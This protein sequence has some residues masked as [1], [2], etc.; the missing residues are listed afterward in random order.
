MAYGTRTRGNSTAYNASGTIGL[1]QMTDVT[2]E[3]FH[4]RLADG[5]LINNPMTRTDYI[6]TGPVSYYRGGYLYHMYLSNGKIF[7]ANNRQHACPRY[8]CRTSELF[9]LDQLKNAGVAACM[10]AGI[11][12][13]TENEENL[14]NTSVDAKIGSGISQL[15]VTLA[16]SRKTLNMIARGMHFL[17]RP[18]SDAKNILRLTREDLRTP[19]GRNRLLDKAGDLW[20]E[21]RYGWRPFVFEVM[22]MTETLLKGGRSAR[23]TARGSLSRKGSFSVSH[24]DFAQ[25]FSVGAL[26]SFGIDVDVNCSY[27]CRVGTT[28]D[29][30][31][32]TQD[33]LRFLLGVYDPLGSTWELVKFSFVIDWFLNIGDVLQSLQ[34]YALVD[35]RIAWV[36]RTMKVE[37][38]HTP[39]YPDPSFVTAQS[40][41]SWYG[42]ISPNSTYSERLVVKTRTPRTTFLPAIGYRFNMDFTKV[43]DSLALLKKGMGIRVNI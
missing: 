8:L 32:D 29:Y 7:Y 11:V 42:P 35:N 43:V 3:N 13:I 4:Q 39:T 10:Q 12:D 27:E 18:L 20:L 1:R 5:E 26:G 9:T 34:A 15:Y 19:A 33:N 36:T 28:V 24:R 40:T 14:L 38:K 17:R 23:Y 21:G 30:K 2:V 37:T 6:C 31:I 25:V 22:G 16:E 41:A